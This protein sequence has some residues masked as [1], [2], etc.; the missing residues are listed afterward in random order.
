MTVCARDKCDNPAED[1]FL[2]MRS[3]FENK[4]LVLLLA[5]LALGALTVLAISLNDVPFRE[6][7]RFG[8]VEAEPSELSIR[9]VG[10]AI[11]D[12]PLW[13]EIVFW[14]LASLL[15]V[16]IG[17]LL[18]PRWRKRLFL[19]IIRAAF[20]VWALY[21]VLI[22]YGDQLVGLGQL[23]ADG[24]QAESAPDVPLPV[25]TPPQVSPAFSYLISFGFALVWLVVLWGLYRGWQKYMAQTHTQKPL[26]EIARIARSSL[27]DLSAGRNSSDVIINCYLRMSDIVSLK[28]QLRR[29]EAATPHEFALHLEQAGLPPEA[30]RRLTHLFERVRYGDRQSSPR[31]ASEAVNCLETILNYCG[32]PV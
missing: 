20:T 1:Q 14:A 24:Q 31:D 27:A 25:F 19:L 23:G 4:R 29:A 13:K 21:F 6:A 5:V 30:V 22:N 17:L 26:D 7:Q 16:L 32:E 12:I 10:G 2:T 8:R 9:D 11:P 3:L 18:S 15:V 28:R